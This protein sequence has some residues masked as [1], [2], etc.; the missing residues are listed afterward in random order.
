MIFPPPADAGGYSRSTPL[1]LVG[2]MT[3]PPP[4]DAG[5]YSRSTPSGLFGVMT[6]PLATCNLLLAT[7]YLLLATCHLIHFPPCRAACIQYH[8]VAEIG[9]GAETYSCQAVIACYY[10]HKIIRY[11][12]VILLYI[13]KLLR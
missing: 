11:H 8:P 9:R 3:I 13:I 10:S 2:V 7:C 6:I 5:G 12:P 4:A 1:G